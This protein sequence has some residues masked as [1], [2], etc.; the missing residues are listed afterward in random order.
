VPAGL[1]T[2]HE[3]MQLDLE[4]ALTR[5]VGAKGYYNLS[6]HLVWIGDRTRQLLGGHVEY[7]R[8]I[9]NPIGCKVGPSMGAEE[10]KQ[11]VKILNPANIEGRLV[12]IT[13]YGKD[14][15]DGLLPAHIKAV[16]ESGIHVVWQADGVHGNTTTGP[17]TKLK[18][19]AWADVVGEIVKAIAIHK[20]CGSHLAGVHIE[21]T[22]QKTVTECTG[23]CVNVLEEQLGTNY[24]TYCDPRLNYGQSIEAA[25]A[26]ADAAKA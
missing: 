13:R 21:M 25:F 20:A 24:E 7:F 8:G 19:R 18:T 16:Q 11:L 14:K 3:A 9:Q 1:F 12:L 10:L 6:A 22:G 17:T 23:G 4:E 5:Q 15:I 2:S 26:I